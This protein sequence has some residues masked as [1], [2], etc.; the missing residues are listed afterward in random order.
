MKKT[1]RLLVYISVIFPIGIL[2]CDNTDCITFGTNTVRIQFL[3]SASNPKSKSFSFIA[4][5][6]SEF[7]FYS[8]T[9]FSTC[10]VPVN[11]SETSTTF[12]FGNPDNSIDSITVGYDRR[13]K[14]ISETC[15]FELKFNNIRILSTTFE[16]ALSL[17]NDL[18]LLNETNIEIYH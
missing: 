11:T 16:H 6:D 14:L 17:E 1:A 9:T 12:L 15:G 2:S 18:S 7:V 4:S 10:I 13:Q 5:T 8:D 3:D